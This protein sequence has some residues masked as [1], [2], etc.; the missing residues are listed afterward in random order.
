MGKEGAKDPQTDQSAYSDF[1][2]GSWA[3]GYFTPEQVDS[4]LTAAL[5]GAPHDWEGSPRD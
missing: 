2:W 4:A 3:P 1:C 5:L